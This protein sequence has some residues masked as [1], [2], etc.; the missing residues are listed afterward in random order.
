MGKEGKKKRVHD[1]GGVKKTT[2]NK[3]ETKMKL[4]KVFGF[5]ENS[6][7]GGGGVFA[8][9]FLCLDSQ[10]LSISHVVVYI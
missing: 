8:R 3:T 4:K 6:R 5:Q 2:E 10:Q 9:R 7:E 1:M